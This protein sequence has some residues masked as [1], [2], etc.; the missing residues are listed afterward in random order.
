MIKQEDINL[1]LSHGYHY[2]HIGLIYFGVNPLV[3]PGINVS[4]LT[5]VIDSHNNKFTYSLLG[6]FEALL[7][8]GPI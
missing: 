8:N 7:H 3:R 5:C 6:V 4:C 1:G 2:V